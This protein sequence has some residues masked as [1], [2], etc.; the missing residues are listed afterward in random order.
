MNRFTLIFTF[1]ISSLSSFSQPFSKKE[2]AIVNTIKQE[3]DSWWQ[4][5]YAKW[6]DTWV[7]KDYVSW[8]GTT[9]FMRLDHQ[10]WNEVNAF[11]KE[12]FEKYP[13]PNQSTVERKNW[14]FRIYKNGAW[15]C[16]TQESEAITREIRI[17]EKKRGQWKIVHVGW[18]NESS[19][20][21]AASDSGN[22]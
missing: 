11:V 20:E 15:V 22:E 5:D 17:L 7:H 8:S 21:E 14:S 1:L 9:N 3:T 13:D 18:I 6:S 2:Q 16:F 4:R 12:S 10:G 19:Y